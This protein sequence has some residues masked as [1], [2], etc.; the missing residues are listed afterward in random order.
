MSEH[1]IDASAVEPLRDVADDVEFVLHPCLRFGVN[2][3][4]LLNK[5][6]GF[7][8]QP[9]FCRGFVAQ[10]VF[11]CVAPNIFGDAHAAEVCCFRAIGGKGFVVELADGF[12]IER[13]I[14][15]I[16]PAKFEAGFPDRVVAAGTNHS[17]IVSSPAI[18]E[19]VGIP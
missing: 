7:L 6:G 2:F 19:N 16:F 13:Q 12:G 17:Q 5:L 1:L 15:L 14:E 4:A 3:R 18:W 8:F 11:R 9:A 10:R